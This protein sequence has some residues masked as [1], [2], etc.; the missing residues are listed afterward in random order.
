MKAASD[1]A[2]EGARPMKHNA[3]KVQLGKATLVRALREA[4]TMTI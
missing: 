2:F 1:K 4:S 3:F